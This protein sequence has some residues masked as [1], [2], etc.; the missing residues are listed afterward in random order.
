MGISKKSAFMSLLS[1]SLRPPKVYREI[2]RVA[3]QLGVGCFSPSPAATNRF[4]SY[5]QTETSIQT[6]TLKYTT[7][8]RGSYGRIKA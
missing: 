1:R 2:S 3:L 4:R 7:E 6:I 8:R 5:I